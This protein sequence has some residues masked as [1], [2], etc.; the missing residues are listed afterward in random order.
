MD[1]FYQQYPVIYKFYFTCASIPY[2]TQQLSIPTLPRDPPQFAKKPQMPES[3][4]PPKTRKQSASKSKSTTATTVTTYYQP[5]PPQTADF[6]QTIQSIGS[7]TGDLLSFGFPG[8]DSSTQQPQQDVFM[9]SS[10]MQQYQQQFPSQ[11]AQPANPFMTNQA[12]P[13]NPF[14]TN[15]AGLS[16]VG[17][18]N[19][20]PA[21]TTTI[22]PVV[23]PERLVAAPVC[24][25]LLK[26]DSNSAPC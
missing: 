10:Q 1:S 25:A 21:P 26:T 16:S 8:G 22:Y 13:A 12:A 24:S 19:V 4:L 23:E 9:T 14:M 7:I 20:V 11:P 17:L 3:K 6:Y 18:A 2:L 5:P 15:T